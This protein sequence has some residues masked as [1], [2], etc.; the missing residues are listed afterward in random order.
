MGGDQRGISGARVG[1]RGLEA[2]VEADEPPQPEGQRVCRSAW[3]RVVVGQL[4]PGND[5]QVVLRSRTL[6]F[7]LDLREVIGVRRRDNRR[8]CVSCGVACP[9][10][11]V[12]DRE[13]VEPERP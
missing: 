4:E 1:Q 5:E 8:A 12:G 13:H 6:G 3:I 2:A 11:V 10:D 9:D 7:G